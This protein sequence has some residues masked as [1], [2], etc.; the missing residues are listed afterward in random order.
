VLGEPHRRQA[1]KPL[2][3]TTKSSRK[4]KRDPEPLGMELAPK[5]KP[6]VLGLN[7]L[8]ALKLANFD[9]VAAFSKSKFPSNAERMLVRDNGLYLSVINLFI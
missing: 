6:A 3:K 1:I 5:Y 2:P 4:E 7:D 8:S 9:P